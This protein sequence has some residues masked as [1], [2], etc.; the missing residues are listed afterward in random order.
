MESARREVMPT[1]NF[2]RHYGRTHIE[3]PKFKIKQKKNDKYNIDT[4][5]PIL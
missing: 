2:A 5:T 3:A 4:M 1:M